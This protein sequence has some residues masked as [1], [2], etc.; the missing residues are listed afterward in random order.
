[1]LFHLWD[2]PRQI[3]ACIH[4]ISL[5]KPQ[6]GSMLIGS[7]LGGLG[8]EIIRL[9][10]TVNENEMKAFRY[11]PRTWEPMWK[12]IGERTGTRWKVNA[13]HDMPEWLVNVRRET[14][15]EMESQKASDRSLKWITFT[16]T[17]L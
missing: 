1:M 17:R 12:E 11:D 16:V 9:G 4:T 10:R 8:S 6:P 15:E 13:I 3:Q 14:I 7:Q 2:L 5:L